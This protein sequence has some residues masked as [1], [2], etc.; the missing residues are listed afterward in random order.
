MTQSDMDSFRKEQKE[1][2]KQFNLERNVAI[3]KLATAVVN[4][5]KYMQ[6][7]YPNVKI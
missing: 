5:L 7:K 6:V 2:A 4:V 3:Q 1:F